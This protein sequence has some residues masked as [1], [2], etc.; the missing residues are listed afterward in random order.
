MKELIQLKEK[1]QQEVKELLDVLQTNA[2]KLDDLVDK[3]ESLKSHNLQ[4]KQESMR[5]SE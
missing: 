4:L 1:A 2:E 3:H 5:L